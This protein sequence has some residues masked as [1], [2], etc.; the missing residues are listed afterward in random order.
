MNDIQHKDSCPSKTQMGEEAKR[1]GQIESLK[2]EG[3]KEGSCGCGASDE[4]IE[5]KRGER[6]S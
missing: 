2:P 3:K 5:D 1:E 6:E 4:K